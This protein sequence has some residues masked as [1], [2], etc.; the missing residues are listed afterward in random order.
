M[1]DCFPEVH[2]LLYTPISDYKYNIDFGDYGH[3]G[4]YVQNGD[5]GHFC[6]NRHFCHNDRNSIILVSIEAYGL[7]E[8]SPG[9]QNHLK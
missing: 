1:H 4:N 9:I 2:T 5:Y 7:Q 6:H 3:N 8:N